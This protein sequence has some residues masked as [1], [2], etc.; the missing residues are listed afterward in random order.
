MKVAI[1]PA[2]GGS[3]RIPRKNIK[4]FCGKPM[5]AW[6]IEAAINS[7]CFDQIIV[8]TDDKEIADIAVKYGAL[9]PFMRP[10]ILADDHA[11]IMLVISHALGHLTSKDN[12]IDYACCINA[13]APFICSEDIKKGFEMIVAADSDYAVSVTSFPFPIQRAVRVTSA[14]NVEMFQPEHFHSHSQDLEE[15]YHDA[16]Q[17]YWGTLNSWV[18][19]KPLYSSKTLPIYLPRYRVQDIDTDE[20]WESAE[21]MFKL[22]LDKEQRLA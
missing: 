14:G 20:D 15:A 5:I 11:D 8:S 6:S 18:N 10:K 13:T 17:L 22:I 21:L 2:R 19:N 9:V 12:V 16:G 3:K 4:S 7:Q 1:I